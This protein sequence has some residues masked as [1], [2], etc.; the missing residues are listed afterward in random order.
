MQG[1]QGEKTL[2]SVVKE[3]AQWE[4]NNQSNENECTQKCMTN[5]IAL[6]GHE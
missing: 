4:R 2:I 6:E 1:E 5:M 3:R